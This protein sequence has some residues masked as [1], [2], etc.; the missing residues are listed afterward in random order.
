MTKKKLP[1]SA[2]WQLT[3]TLY[4]EQRGE[5]EI[6]FDIG[7][8]KSDP[9]AEEIDQIQVAQS[10]AVKWLKFHEKE[11]ICDLDELARSG[12]EGLQ[13]EFLKGKRTHSPAFERVA[14]S[15]GEKSII[16]QRL[17]FSVDAPSLEEEKTSAASA[18][19]SEKKSAP[20]PKPKK[21]V[22]GTLVRY[23]RLSMEECVAKLRKNEPAISGF[24]V[25]HRIK[26]LEISRNPRDED[27]FSTIMKITLDKEDEKA[28]LRLEFFSRAHDR[29][30]KPTSYPVMM[31]FLGLLCIVG[32]WLTVLTKSFKT[33]SLGFAG[34]AVLTT[35][36]I[37]KN[38]RAHGRAREQSLMENQ[39][40]LLAFIERYLRAW[41]EP[42][43]VVHA[44][45]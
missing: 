17:S 10:G 23:S 37:L 26:H 42:D 38:R 20:P 34:L 21:I 2:R 12:L 30:K 36:I 9:T 5:K 16:Y 39:P 28:R 33:A 31:I 8:F 14:F 22:K 4:L 44:E 41:P 29:F 3:E 7:P 19:K 45:K 13:K 15:E 24:T 32:G 35:L 11:W 27:R 6:L 1:A 43:P 25:A 40:L 18:V